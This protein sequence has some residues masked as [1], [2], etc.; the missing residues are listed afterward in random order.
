MKISKKGGEPTRLAPSIS[1]VMNFVADES[2]IYYFDSETASTF[3]LRK[4]SI[5]GGE[6]TTLDR[7]QDSW[8]KYLAVDQTQVYFTTI[9]KVYV[10]PK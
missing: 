3:A 2:S 7:G 8:N 4:V 9:A 6:P 10:V 1:E 5:T